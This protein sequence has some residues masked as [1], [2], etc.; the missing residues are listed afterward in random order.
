M[1]QIMVRLQT[2]RISR[3]C[4]VLSRNS[5][6][7]ALISEEGLSGVIPTSIIRDNHI[8]LS[9]NTLTLSE[10]LFNRWILEPAITASEE[11][12]ENWYV[13]NAE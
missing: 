12:V 9:G 3:E 10:G 6:H 11:L 4:V 5:D 7:V 8:D 1:K 13:S 2:E